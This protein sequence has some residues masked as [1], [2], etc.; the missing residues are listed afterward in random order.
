LIIKSIVSHEHIYKP[1]FLRKKKKKIIPIIMENFKVISTVS[2]A[3]G[4][5]I[6]LISAATNVIKKILEI[7]SEAEHNKNIC[8]AFARRVEKTSAALESITQRK[9]QIETQLRDKAYYDAFHK[10]IYVLEEIKEFTTNISTIRGLRKYLNTNSLKGKFINLTDDYDKVMSDLNFTMAVA[11]EEQ[12][13]IERESL[14]KD[15]TEFKKFLDMISGGITSTNEIVGNVIDEIKFIKALL[16]DANKIDSKDLAPPPQGNSDDVRSG[17][18]PNVIVR[19]IFKG[20]EVACR[21]ILMTEKEMNSSPE[22]RKL[23]KILT[24]LSDCDYILKFYG[25]SKIDINNVMILEW[26]GHGTLRELYEKIDISWHFKVQIALNICRGL[27]FLQQFGILHHDLKCENILMTKT[28]EPKIYKFKLARYDYVGITTL[29]SELNDS[30]RWLAPEKLSNPSARYTTQCEIFSFSM[31]LW[32]LAFEKVPYKNMEK[33]EL[34]KEHVTK[35]GREIIEFGKTTPEI[36]KLQED[37][38]RIIN[39]CKYYESFGFIIH[40]IF[41]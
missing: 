41:L 23:F 6:P 21:K 9:E 7:C 13:R 3:I 30:V 16:H 24:I 4:P 2:D 22:V 33:I 11:N 19:K 34:I 14:E 35:G 32:E 40:S 12:R 29:E 18:I 26:A 31:L 5:Y 8:L 20:Q 36:S 1:V 37:Y 28:L 27:I 38:K 17:R 39:D 15:L 25:V 10:L